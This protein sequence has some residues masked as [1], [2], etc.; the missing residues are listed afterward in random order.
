[1]TKYFNRCVFTNGEKYS[2]FINDFRGTFDTR[3]LNPKFTPGLLETP[4]REVRL[5]LPHEYLGDHPILEEQPPYTG[6]YEE[7]LLSLKDALKKH[8]LSLDDDT[9]YLFSHSSGMDSRFISGTMAELRDQKSFKNVHFR[10]HAPENSVFKKIME[11]SGWDKDQ[12]S[13]YDPNDSVYDIGIENVCV[14]GWQSYSN[15]MNFWPDLNPKEWVII[16]GEGGE[17]FKYMARYKE[18]P[19]NYTRNY[20]LNMLIQHN[21]G[22]GEWDNQ[23]KA[24]FKDAIMPLWSFDYLS[25]SNRV[26]AEFVEPLDEIGYD[27]VR[28]DL[29][30]GVGLSDFPYVENDYMVSWV[31][32]S[33]R[34]NKMLELFYNSN[35]YKEF[36]KLIPKDID[37]FTN[38][39][40]WESK[41]WGFGVTVYK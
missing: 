15:Q 7:Y 38:P 10:C 1:M 19:F 5:A 6:T 3:F 14:N 24:I 4:Y 33:Y 8:L 41:V 25:V 26:R 23:N 11:K 28:K 32:N 2:P 17:L 34:R 16:T 29:V 9:K 37:F 36:H 27:N 31:I 18:K 40:G 22:R 20:H 30:K 35:F 13:T 12:Y 21:P 39:F